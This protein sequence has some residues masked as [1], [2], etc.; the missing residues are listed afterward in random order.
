M[1][2]LET[3]RVLPSRVE[4]LKALPYTLDIVIRFPEKVLPETVD[5]II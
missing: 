1:L 3:A 5:T 2:T 4:K